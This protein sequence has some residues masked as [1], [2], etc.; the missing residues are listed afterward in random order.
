MNTENKTSSGFR[1]KS[2]ALL[3]SD[4]TRTPSLTTD[5]SQKKN[6]VD[7]EVSFETQEKTLFIIETL[8]FSQTVNDKEEI[9]AHIK[10]IGEFESFGDPLLPIEQ[11]A[12]VNGPAIIFPFIREHLASL[13]TKAGV[14]MILLSPINFTKRS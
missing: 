4:F 8:N 3:Q 7:V 13:C 10:M 5:E 12:K 14:G 2:I 9:K 11:F 1:I 6:R